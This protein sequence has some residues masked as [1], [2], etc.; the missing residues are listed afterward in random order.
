MRWPEDTA[1]ERQYKRVTRLKTKKKNLRCFPTCDPDGHKAGTFCGRTVA[2]NIEYD[3]RA[4]EALDI[5]T[6][7]EFRPV[8]GG[9]NGIRLGTKFTYEEVLEKSR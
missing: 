8:Y 1:F 2:V 9:Q 4:A 7:A 3:L 5:I 6:Y